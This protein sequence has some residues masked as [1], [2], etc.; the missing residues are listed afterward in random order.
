MKV[1]L[2]AGKQLLNCCLSVSG[3]KVEMKKEP[4]TP[5]G[6][7]G[8]LVGPESADGLIKLLTYLV[9]TVSRMDLTTNVTN[10]HF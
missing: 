3:V 5:G 6:T 8:K 10:S 1:L 2:K 9:A 4:N 7:V